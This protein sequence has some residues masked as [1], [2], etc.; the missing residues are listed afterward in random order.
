MVTAEQL[1]VAVRAGLSAFEAAL[2]TARRGILIPAYFHPGTSPAPWDEIIKAAARVPI[3]AIV[4][5]SSGPGTSRSAAYAD[6]ITRLRA[7]G[8]KPI[9]YVS[10]DYAKRLRAE[11][12]TDVQRWKQYYPEIGG[13]FYDEQST[14]PDQVDHYAALVTLARQTIPGGKVVTNPGT[15]CDRGYYD[16]AR[17]DVMVLWEKAGGFPALPVWAQDAPDN[18]FAMLAHAIS[19]K[20]TMLGIVSATPLSG[21]GWSYVTDRILGHG[22]W[23][24]LPSYWLDEVAAVA[25]AS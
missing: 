2:G 23:G 7:A 3:T 11:V 14:G 22:L 9:G 19:D 20:Q 13:I 1:L 6:V 4:N 12:T 24:G 5:P 10:T 21:F 25:A 16:R 18:F 8:G 17:P 15:A